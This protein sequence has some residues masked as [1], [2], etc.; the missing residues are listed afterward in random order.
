MK[1]IISL[2]LITALLSALI[3]CSALE[4]FL[5]DEGSGQVIFNPSSIEENKI[6][7][8][9]CDTLKVTVQVSSDHSPLD[10]DQYLQFSKLNEE[11]QR[12]Y[13]AIEESVKIAD[14]SVDLTEYSL[15]YKRAMEIAQ[16]IM[17]DCPQYFYL[18]KYINATHYEGSDDAVELRLY[19]TDGTVTDEMEGKKLVKQADRQIIEKQITEFNNT[20]IEFLNSI[21]SYYSDEEMT[22]KIH[23]FIVSKVS[24]DQAAAELIN[25]EDMPPA[26]TAYGALCNKKAV[27]EGYAKLFQYFCYGV[28]INAGQVY[29]SG[30]G[31]PHMWNVVE[32][33]GRWLHSDLTWDDP[34]G[35][36]GIYYDYYNISW[37]QM[38]KDHQMDKNMLYVPK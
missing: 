32:V 29:G 23:D 9:D 6:E 22:K 3:G 31:E 33:D 37:D 38:S 25:T 28:G 13:R 10:P 15:S 24:Y 14:I 1:K 17:A 34:I 4:R 19:Y 21:P 12:V 2:L 27:C 18:S 11:E 30:D 36:T 35:G 26:Y 16:I 7:R 8:V 20:A 5:Y